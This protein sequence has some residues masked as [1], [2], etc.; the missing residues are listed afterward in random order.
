MEYS[1]SIMPTC[2]R[3]RFIE[4]R[5]TSLHVLLG[6]LP[7][8]SSVHAQRDQR[9]EHS[10][11]MGSIAW[12]S[13]KC[14]CRHSSKCDLSTATFT[15]LLSICLLVTSP[16]VNLVHHLLCFQA[17]LYRCVKIIVN[18]GFGKSVLPPMCRFHI[19]ACK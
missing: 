4:I 2:H 10:G 17:R 1:T 14:I 16:D 5:S 3:S 9:M 15:L 7:L 13:Q 6:N 11:K 19:I 8:F 18:E 12:R